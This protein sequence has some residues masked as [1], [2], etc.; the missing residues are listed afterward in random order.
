MPVLLATLRTMPSSPP[1]FTSLLRLGQAGSDMPK[2][3][4][5]VHVGPLAGRSEI[6]MPGRRSW[7]VDCAVGSPASG[8]AVVVA[9]FLAMWMA[10]SWRREFLVLA[11][12]RWWQRSDRVLEV[13]FWWQRVVRCT[14]ACCEGD[15]G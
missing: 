14:V 6:W 2:S 9:F 15:F 4:L 3:S 13:L 10:R 11:L 7:K 12:L 8:V 5:F 1:L